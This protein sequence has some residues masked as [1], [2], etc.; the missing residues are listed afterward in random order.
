MKILIRNKNQSEWE[1]IESMGYEA[2]KELQDILEKTP[3][4]INLEDIREGAAPLLVAIREFGLPGSGNTDL[5]AFNSQGDIVIVEC[6]LAANQEIK[7]KVVAQVLEYAA[8]LWKMPYDKLNECVIQRSRGNKNLADLVEEAIADPEWN[9]EAFETSI[10]ETLDKGSFILVIAVD[11]INDELIRT[12]RYLNSC[13]NPEFIFTVLEMER[14]KWDNIQI[15]VPHLHSAV[16]QSQVIKARTK[17]KQWTEQEFFE[18]TSKQNGSQVYEVIQKL[19]KWSRSVADRVLFGTGA[20]RGS[21]AF[22][23]LKDGKTISI[24]SVNTDGTL[25]LNYIWLSKQIGEEMINKFHQE[26]IKIPSFAN[27]PANFNTWPILNIRETFIDHPEYLD[28]FMQVV[29]DFGQVVKHTHNMN[30]KD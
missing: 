25:M 22:Q 8:Y 19:Y 29:T 4:I 23:Y 1:T 18:R 27:I 11:K 5:L 24:F 16:T 20:E 2:E 9:K 12:V 14:Y 6:K 7:R 10:K 15:L 17:R 28:K 30:D 3:S 26:L 21:F 13:G